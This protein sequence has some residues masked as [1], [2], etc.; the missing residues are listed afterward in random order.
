MISKIS[1]EKQILLESF[2]RRS[3]KRSN[4]K[5]LMDR[6][7]QGKMSQIRK[8]RE[9]E[10]DNKVREWKKQGTFD[11]SKLG[12]NQKE[13]IS[14][15]SRSDVRSFRNLHEQRL[16]EDSIELGKILKELE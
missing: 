14:P 3:L 6:M 7:F 15:T 13:R 1:K 9:E 11:M 10:Y 5:K 12:F 8:H 4:T 2:N 16:Y